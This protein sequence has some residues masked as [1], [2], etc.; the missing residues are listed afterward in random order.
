MVGQLT[1]SQKLE[2]PVL[3]RGFTGNKPT[4]IKRIDQNFIDG[5]LAELTSRDLHKI[6]SSIA[7]DRDEKGTLKLF[8]PVHR[9]FYIVLLEVV[10][11]PY[12]QTY[13]QPRLDP[14]KIE[15]A[16]LVVRRI[17]QTGDKKE[18]WRKYNNK[19]QGWIPFAN[20]PEEKLD[21]D[22]NLRSPLLSA[23]HPELDRLLQA[24]SPNFSESVSSLFIAPPDVCQAAG[25][26]ILYGLIPLASSEVSEIPPQAPT[27]E[28]SASLEQLNQAIRDLLPYYL[29]S[30]YL[31][32]DEPDGVPDAERREPNSGRNLTA[33]DADVQKNSQTKQGRSL[34]I[35]ISSL[36]QLNYHFQVFDNNAN[37]QALFNELNQIILNFSKETDKKPLGD[38]LKQ[39]TQIL[40]N[41]EAGQVL[42]PEKWPAIAPTRHQNIVN[43]IRTILMN[44]LANLTAGETR[45]EELGRQY[46]I[47]AFVRVKRPDGCPP[48]LFW[49]DYSEPFTIAAWYENSGLPPVKVVLP[50]IL[51]PKVLANLKPSVAFT[52]PPNLFNF[53]QKNQPDKLLKGE[54]NQGEESG[55][56]WICSFNIPI[57]TLCAYIVLN[58]FL[59]LFNLFFQWLFI[60]KICIPIPKKK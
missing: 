13:I 51:N 7:S 1:K 16:G 8:P 15:N 35:F 59:Q 58:I 46:Q 5:I 2:H 42:M 60:I 21:P 17:A 49:S 23:G 18:G 25:R 4:I 40:V 20:L 50:D 45:F 57:I 47:Q 56:A 27:P 3:L 32:P 55:L 52:V 30:S 43:L 39:A 6:A 11:D 41:R 14:Q 33:N 12:A 24:N 31:R 9:T 37:S 38:F 19:L 44:Q 54:G 10:C 34:N 29:R 53:L 22:P 48:E 26:T 28:D 36:Q